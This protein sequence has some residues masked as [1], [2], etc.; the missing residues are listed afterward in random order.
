MRQLKRQQDTCK[1]TLIDEVLAEPITDESLASVSERT[2]D[3]QA[4]IKQITQKD[5]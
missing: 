3:R 2:G 1:G 4:S 5:I